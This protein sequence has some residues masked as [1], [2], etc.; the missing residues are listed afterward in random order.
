LV[1]SRVHIAILGGDFAVGNGF[2]QW[3]DILFELI[4]FRSFSSLWYWLALSVVW[5]TAS[6]WVLGV[7]YDLIRRARRD[8]QAQRDLEDVL[9]VNVH[10]LL[11]YA[12]GSGLVSVALAAFVLSALLVLAV[13]GVEFAQAVLCILL[14]MMPIFALRLRLALEFER[15]DHGSADLDQVLTRHRT[16]VQTIGALAIFFTGLFGMYQ[17]LRLGAL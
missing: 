12:R 3:Y 13:R 2:L 11:F 10:R 5:S 16:A 15:G 17:N 7:P 8:E 14:P 1:G 6:H 4:D 9:R